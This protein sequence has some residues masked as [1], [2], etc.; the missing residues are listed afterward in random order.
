MEPCIK[1]GT[2]EKGGCAECGAPYERIVKAEGGTIGRDWNQNV[3]GGLGKG[4]D[5]EKTPKL[6]RAVADGSY[7]RVDLGWH[8]TCSCNASNPVPCLVLD[9]FAGSGTLGV[10]AL[11]L[12]RSFVGLE[13]QPDYVEMA[14]RRIENDAPLL[15]RRTAPPP[16]R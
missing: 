5:I 13:L 2:S 4:E 10:V 1:A 15:N 8:P 3:R 6:D 16:C 7:R 14:R 9:P 12:G 11:R